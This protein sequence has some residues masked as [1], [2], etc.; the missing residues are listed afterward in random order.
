MGVVYRARD[1]RLRREVA[2]KVLHESRDDHPHRLRRFLEEARAAGALNHPNIL[3][4]YDVSV[5]GDTPYIATELIDGASLRRTIEAGR[6]P[7]GRLL[8]IATQIADGLTAA[9]RASL[10]HRDL[11]PENVMVTR[12]GRA[13]I[14]DFGLARTVTPAEDA[15]DRTL[16][17]PHA[18][19]GTTGYMSPE[20][21]RGGAIDFRSDLFSLG[22][23]LYEMAVGRRPFDRATP[24][25]TLTAI[26]H[27]EP[28]LDGIA[29]RLPGP[30]GSI[31]ARC[32]AKDPQDRYAATQ[33]LHYDLR[34]LRD[35]P[36]TTRR[37]SRGGSPG[38]RRMIA[39]WPLAM[40]ATAIAAAV[41]MFLW[42]FAMAPAA[43]SLAD[44]AIVPFATEAVYE[45]SAAWSPDGRTIAYVAERDGIIQVMARG[46][47]A[48]TAVAVTDAASDCR[49]PF[50]S[51]DGT[52]IFYI[53]WAGTRE[54]LWSIGSAGGAAHVV[55][56]DVSV[57]TMRPDGSA[58]VFL[59]QKQGQTE[60][61]QTLWVSAV[62]GSN[63]RR[64][65]EGWAGGETAGISFMSFSPDGRSLGLW[66]NTKGSKSSAAGGSDSADLWIFAF[67]S[68]DARRVLSS[69]G[70]VP[71]AHPFTWLPDSRHIV[72]GADG[73]GRSPG[74]HLWIGDIE[75]NRIEP[76]TNTASSEYEPSASPDGARIAFTS[77]S[78]HYDL[79]E[80]PTDGSP[81]R[82]RPFN[83]RELAEPS[84]S[85]KAGQFAY[86]TDRAGPQEIW[87][88]NE[89]GS[90]EVPAVTAKNFSDTTYLLSRVAF[91]P[92]GTRLAYQRRSREG[93][94]IWM[95]QAAGGPA[96]RLLNGR[97]AVYEDAPAWSP[98][99]QWIA[100]SYRDAQGKWW[101]GKTRAGA[102]GQIEPVHEDIHYP[103]M[104]QWS[105]DG[106][107]I[108]C[109]LRD[110]LYVLAVDGREQR[111][112]SRE[113]WLSHTW[114]HD[115]RSIFAV[116]ETAE[117][118]LQLVAIDVRTQATRVITAD[119]GP[120]PP[121]TPPLRGFSLSPDGTRILT[122]IVQLRGDLHLLDGISAPRGVWSRVTRAFGW[123]PVPRSSP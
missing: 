48:G 45:G 7:L 18:V 82:P 62:D 87:R 70:Q 69:L 37:I 47:D 68:G 92:D 90:F 107:W 119:L 36:S 83:S 114:S 84:W 9:H 81:I 97:L 112:I 104:P 67:P 31:V 58:L 103:A 35:R 39:P 79:V 14:V 41:A 57:A 75:S 8:D 3:A 20:Q 99:G 24:I 32:L 61:A 50:W 12:E 43:P 101:L 85:A 5:D 113:P 13:K 29:D 40:T 4:V 17:A 88:S 34:A 49:A 52:R 106:H 120:S 110:G 111:L 93:Y 2:I 76:L 23:M 59:R 53:S 74:T 27:D 72:F 123:R 64:F 30:L 121:T 77:E 117:N 60:L 80:I 54:G 55:L 38:G 96:A 10:V 118:R 98:D 65:A 19:L 109:E 56:E 78:T 105:P 33:D 66:A 11:K 51:A 16:T 94:Y 71:R 89:N 95:S 63:P 25:E 91:S 44:A 21:A 46:I 22:T 73:L 115:G 15:A 26:L 122:S 1:T 6:I 108:L 28:P 116:S 102:G 100:F 42:G 86:I